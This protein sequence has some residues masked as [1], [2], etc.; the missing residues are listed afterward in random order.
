MMKQSEV[1]RSGG[2]TV[3]LHV[4]SHASGFQANTL[5]RDAFE[6]LRL[7]RSMKNSLA[8]INR[9]PP[10]IL[11][12][13]PDYYREDDMDEDLVALTHVCRGWRDAFI[14][15]SSLWTKL[16]LIDTDKTHTYIQRSQ[17]SPLELY[18]RYDEVIDHAFPLITPHIR[19]LKSLTVDAYVFPNVLRH[20]FC[21]APLLKKLDIS[22][23]APDDPVLDATLFNGD[24]SSLHEL[25]FFGV[26]TDF[27]WKNLANLRVVTLKLYSQRCGTTHILDFL[28][29]APLLQTVLL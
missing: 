17:S 20:F 22:I 10:E 26:V 9:I 27:P 14:S 29:S 16:D 2:E 8:P 23:S 11:S 13:I 24:F 1:R 18:L 15:R 12:L 28:E 5:E 4:V 25:H 21:H 3:N 19:Q 6:V 7:V